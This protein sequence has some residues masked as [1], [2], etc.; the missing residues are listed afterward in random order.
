MAIQGVNA[1]KTTDGRVFLTEAEAMAA[2]RDY[3]LHSAANALA[4]RIKPAYGDADQLARDLIGEDDLVIRLANAMLA[5]QRN[6]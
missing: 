2:E 6:G 4:D 3:D 1:W 5:I